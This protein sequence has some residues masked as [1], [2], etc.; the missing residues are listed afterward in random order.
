MI[1]F[2]TI[3]RLRSNET[4]KETPYMETNT[5]KPLKTRV[6]FKKES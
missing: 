1:K 3:Q 2:D 4:I 6:K 5:Q